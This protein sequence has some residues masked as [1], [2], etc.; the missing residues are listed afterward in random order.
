MQQSHSTP[1]NM[2]LIAA[3]LAA[4]ALTY[5]PSSQGLWDFWSNDNTA[6]AHGF[7]VA[8]LALWLLYRARHRLAAVEVRPSRAACVMLVLW[9]IAWLVFWRSGLQELHLLS[10][11][12]LMGLSVWAA[13]GR[14]AAWIVA[15]PLGY[16]YFAVPAWGIFIN[17][18]EHLTAAAVGLLAPYIGVPA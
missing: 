4:A 15:F 8:A 5:W 3:L 1:G 17:P 12:V 6:G 14:Q 11:P 18:L 16:L 9:S 7:L 10:L 2:V 13:L